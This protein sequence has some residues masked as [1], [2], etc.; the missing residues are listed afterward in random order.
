MAPNLKVQLFRKLVAPDASECPICMDMAQ[1]G[2]ISRCGHGPFC[3]E[4]MNTLLH[5]SVSL[6]YDFNMHHPSFSPLSLFGVF[7][8]EMKSSQSLIAQMK[9]L[10]L[11][12]AAYIA[13]CCIGSHPCN[14]VEQD[15]YIPN[16]TAASSIVF[17]ASISGSI[18]R[19]L[20]AEM[21][22]VG[23]CS[24]LAYAFRFSLPSRIWP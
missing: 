9:S 11:P 8:K 21:S 22:K 3:R 5:N 23:V 2:V 20:F 15:V 17:R 12:I 4:C 10:Y 7:C 19:E 6:F 16:Y 18:M 13:P 1:D 14:T 24:F